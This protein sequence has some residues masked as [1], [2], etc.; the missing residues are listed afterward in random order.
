MSLI[1][2]S[3]TQAAESESGQ[4]RATFSLR[5]H[6]LIAVP[7]LLLSLVVGGA[8]LAGPAQAAETPSCQSLPGATCPSQPS[9]GITGSSTAPQAVPRG[10]QAALNYWRQLSWPN[11]RNIAQRGAAFEVENFNDAR[12]RHI[13]GWI[14]SGGQ[15]NDN[16]GAL[17]TFMHNG[18]A[19]PSARNYQGSFQEYYGSVYPNN[20]VRSGIATGNFR[21]VRALGT[22]DVWVSIDHYSNFRY[23]G[24]P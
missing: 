23:I 9:V 13:E 1:E 11:F 20:P 15:Y 5:R 16:G 12:G 4:S 18:N 22:G 2:A 6:R 3:S 7:T 10:I 19:G 14:E 8:V 24:R 17:M 21:I